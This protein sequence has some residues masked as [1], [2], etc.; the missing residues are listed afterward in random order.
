MG[1][2]TQFTVDRFVDPT[3]FPDFCFGKKCLRSES[4]PELFG[5]ALL[6]HEVLKDF[7]GGSKKEHVRDRQQKFMHAR[8]R[9]P[10]GT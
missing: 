1:S 10:F 6:Q 2:G 5:I 3:P 7:F 4:S 9:N 8:A